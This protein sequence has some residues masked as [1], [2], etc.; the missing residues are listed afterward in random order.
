MDNR[1][2]EPFLPKKVNHSPNKSHFW[3]HQNSSNKIFLFS[4]L[5]LDRNQQNPNSMRESWEK[6]KEIKERIETRDILS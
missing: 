6:Q 4:S 3:I 1:K 5:L 2:V